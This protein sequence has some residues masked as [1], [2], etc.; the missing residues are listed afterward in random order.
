MSDE[1]SGFN[2]DALADEGVTGDFAAIA[3]FRS[4][5]NFD[6]RPDAS[7]VANFAAVEI[8]ECVNLHVAT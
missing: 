1:N 3:D 5:L 2:S 4:L 6:K 7:F 8:H